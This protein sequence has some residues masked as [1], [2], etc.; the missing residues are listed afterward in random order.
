MENR[1]KSVIIDQKEF[2]NMKR[3]IIILLIMGFAVGI[4][5][6]N[7][8]E[9]F[10]KGEEQFQQSNWEDALYYYKLALE[11][12]KYYS[13]A[14][15]RIIDV[16]FVLKNNKE[17][18]KYIDRLLK[19][20]P[21]SIEGLLYKGKLN[22]LNKK[23]DK[24]LK[25][26]LA[27][28]KI[29]PLHYDALLGMAQVYT[30]KKYYTQAS[31]NLKKV[32]K[33]DP[34]NVDGYIAYA[35]L[36]IR[37]KKYNTA[38][39]YLKK[40]EYYNPANAD[41]YFHYGLIYEKE[42]NLKDAKQYYEKSY[43]RN[44]DNTDVILN[45]S[46][47]YFK[48]KEWKKAIQFIQNSIIKFPQLAILHNKLGLSYQFSKDI[49]KA[50]K[51]FQQAHSIDSTDDIIS[52]HLENVLIMKKS[53][54]NE[55]RKSLAKIH[56]DLAE[57]NA[58]NFY[59]Y[60]A[61]YEYKRGL[62]LFSQNWKQRYDLGLLYKRMG[63]LEKYLKELS[64][65]IMLNPDHQR[66]K[67]KLNV[68]EKFKKDRLSYKYKIDQ[69]KV[70]KD[71]IK[72]FIP[73]LNKKDNNYINNQVGKVSADSMGQHLNMYNRFEYISSEKDNV[74]YY[75]NVPRNKIRKDAKSNGA[76]YYIYGSVIENK[77]YLSVKF[78]LYSI[79][80]D[81]PIKTFSSVARGKNKLYLL[82]KDISQ[83]I[84]KFFPVSGTIIN[85]N[86]DHII[87]NLGQDVDIKKGD[88]FAVYNKGGIIKNYDLHR[89][90]KISPRKNGTAKIIRIDEQIAEAKLEKI[91]YINK[92]SIYDK[93]VFIKKKKKKGKKK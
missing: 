2:I 90:E 76:D 55:N 45:L 62:Q 86:Y 63:F 57:K 11:K 25:S 67:D 88:R 16:N 54:Y 83:Q 46:D 18:K 78:K 6:E 80:R 32:L 33:I 56:F 64:I 40:G 15:L 21:N 23:Y 65:A 72:I 35:Q 70:K 61:L 79:K 34:N 4:W 37:Q 26:F 38:R 9:L 89:F 14:L 60:D 7:A 75:F 68:A 1:D 36:Y 27:I 39:K 12:N 13:K 74:D 82:S 73:G 53:F 49:E 71:K 24:A 93:V 81:D 30:K 92:V 84:N 51:S 20:S 59:K 87:I 41:V 52:F 19:V 43:Y 17:A 47:I 10:Q 31:K 28:K 66:L 85:V 8:S 48:L 69:Y 22:I 3:L 58:K 77:D 91:D 29:E 5:A 42:G 50:I 44:T